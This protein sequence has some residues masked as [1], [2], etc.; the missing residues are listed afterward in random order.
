M[1]PGFSGPQIG[2]HVR[3][4]ALRSHADIRDALN[5]LDWRGFVLRLVKSVALMN[6]RLCSLVYSS[7]YS[8]PRSPH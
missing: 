1:T 7:E 3:L 4:R 2:G 8:S 5:V 6:G